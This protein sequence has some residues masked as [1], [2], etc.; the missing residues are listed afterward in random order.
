LVYSANDMAYVLAEAADGSWQAFVDEM[1]RTAK[2][3]GLTGTHF[4]NPN[5]LFDPRHISTARDIALLAQTIL[6]EFPEHSHYFSQAYVKVGKRRLANRNSL[7]RQMPEAD[8]MKTGFVCDSGFN[9]VASATHKGRKL[10]AVVFGAQSGKARADL[11]QML[12]TDGFTRDPGPA[13]RPKLMQLSNDPLG[14]IVPADMTASVCKQKQAVSLASARDLTGWGISFGQYDSP[15]K[16]DMALRGRLLSPSGR[17]AGGIAG[18]VHLPGEAGYAAMLW[19]IDQ[20]RSLTLCAN[21]RV[22]K[23]YCDVMTP[24]SFAQLAAL[25]PEPKSTPNKKPQAQ[26]SDSGK[27]KVQPVSGEN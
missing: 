20:S 9:L 16:A 27:S 2:D 26:G 24:E 4:A 22:E 19:N 6:S 17:D 15:D 1:N 13:P 7:I 21:Y 18:V 23:A 8:G 3:L 25:T 5:G 14:A 10:V 12:L 11:A